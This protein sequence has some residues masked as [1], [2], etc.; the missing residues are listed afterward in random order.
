ML[1]KAAVRGNV[2]DVGRYDDEGILL[3]SKVDMEDF[4][5]RVGSG[6]CYNLR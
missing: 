3:Q 1:P 2:V 6:I 5:G 4:A